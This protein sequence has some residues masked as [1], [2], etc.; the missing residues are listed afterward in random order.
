MNDKTGQTQ[1]DSGDT[2]A[3][4]VVNE[5]R[6]SGCSAW[7]GYPPPKEIERLKMEKSERDFLAKK[8]QIEND[9]HRRAEMK[10]LARE[11]IRRNQD[12]QF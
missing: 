5:L 12:G 1:D 7:L 3:Q 11:V 8:R 6:K 4:I 10:R 2:L 9:D